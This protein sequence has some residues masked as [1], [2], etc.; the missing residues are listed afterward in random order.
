MKRTEPTSAVQR[1]GRTGLDLVLSLP[2][3]CLKQKSIALRFSRSLP[4][5]FALAPVVTANLRWEF[6]LESTFDVY[7]NRSFGCIPSYEIGE[8]FRAGEVNFGEGAADCHDVRHGQVQSFVRP[9]AKMQEKGREDRIERG[10]KGPSKT[11]RT[12]IQPEITHSS[13]FCFHASNRTKSPKSIQ[14]ITIPREYASAKIGSS[15]S[16]LRI[17]GAQN[18]GVQG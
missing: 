13:F 5:A 12:Q 8:Q 18:G 4:I 9:K 2:P 11:K 10:E 3:L 16:S 7:T 14:R 1:T 6:H 15:H 17:S